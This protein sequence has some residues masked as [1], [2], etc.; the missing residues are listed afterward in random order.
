MKFRK[1]S[2][3]LLL[4]LP[5]LALALAPHAVVDVEEDANRLAGEA[6]PPSLKGRQGLPTKDAPVDG[7]DGKPHLGP[8]VGSDTP[9]DTDHQDRPSLKGRPEDPTIVDGKKI[10]ETNDGVMFDKNREKPLEGTTG[11]EGGVSSKS[12]ARKFEE[13]QTG[14]KVVTQPKSP[15]EVPPL[16]HSEEEKLPKD[17]TGQAADDDDA[18][19][20]GL[21][22]S[23][24]FIWDVITL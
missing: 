22:V 11:T 21:E 20:A 2:P 7:K 8:F 3:L 23:T 10:P 12:K 19:Y 9:G 5:S 16:P 1:H 24:A 4:L 17:G 6:L 13:G 14:E 18:S 15:K